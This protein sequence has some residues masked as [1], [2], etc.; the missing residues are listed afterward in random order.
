G[1]P[2]LAYQWYTGASANT[3]SP[4]AGATAASLTVTPSSTTSYWARVTN[5]TSP[6]SCWINSNTS[7]VSVCALPSISTQPGA[8]VIQRGNA[9]TLSVSASGT[10][11]S[12]QWYAGATGVTTSPVTGGT[13]ASVSVSPTYTTSYWVKVSGCSTSVNSAAAQV[14]VAPVI[15]V[16]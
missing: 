3:A 10:N 13:A 14:S 4:I 2:T 11:V 6:A 15:T 7:T 12:Y 1:D 8:R 5:G 9:A 16:Q